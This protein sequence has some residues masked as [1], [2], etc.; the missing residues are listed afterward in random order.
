MADARGNQIPKEEVAK[1]VRNRKVRVW[2]GV[3]V[4]AACLALAFLTRENVIGLML[5][6]MV[7]FGTE[8]I[9]SITAVWR[10]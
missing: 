4:G 8:T 6:A 1:R 3:A 5:I 10:R 7:G 9:A 2:G